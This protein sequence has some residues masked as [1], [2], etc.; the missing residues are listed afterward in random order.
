ER[1]SVVPS[2]FAIIDDL[3]CVNAANGKDWFLSGMNSLSASTAFHLTPL[4][5]ETSDSHVSHH[6]FTRIFY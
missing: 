4:A 5:F 3:T 2:C 1:T 6:R